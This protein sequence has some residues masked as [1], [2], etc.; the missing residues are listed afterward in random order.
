APGGPLGAGRGSG[1]VLQGPG[2]GALHAG[3]LSHVWREG[4]AR[5]RRTRARR[6]ARRLPGRRPRGARGAAHLRRLEG[7]LVRD[8]GRPPAARGLPAGAL[9]TAVA[10][11]ARR[12]CPRL[13][14]TRASISRR[15]TC[16]RRTDALRW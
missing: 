5:E 16:H 10:P 4:A 15:A 8:R 7:A 6:R 2:G 13:I 9:S 3:V 14:E 1:R 11:R 12:E